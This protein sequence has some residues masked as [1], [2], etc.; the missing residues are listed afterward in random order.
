MH[1]PGGSAG[2]WT[3]HK[4][5]WPV[6]LPPEPLP[7]SGRQVAEACGGGGPG[8]GAHAAS[9]GGWQPKPPRRP[10]VTQLPVCSRG[11]T[12]TQVPRRSIHSGPGHQGTAVRAARKAPGARALPASS[13]G[14][15]WEAHGAGGGLTD[16]F[17]FAPF[18]TPEDDG[19]PGRRRRTQGLHL[20]HD[21]DGL[22]RLERPVL[23]PARHEGTVHRA[24][25]LKG[26]LPTAARAAGVPEPRSPE[27]PAC[28][29]SSA[30]ADRPK[31]PGFVHW[32][33]QP[34]THCGPSDL[35]G[36]AQAMSL[37]RDP[38]QVARAAQGPAVPAT[39]TTLLGLLSH[40][41]CRC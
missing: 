22:L 3:T 29:G 18:Q 25:G 17:L 7:S 16:S 8:P 23:C 33:P 15:V 37:S 34:A 5:W 11:Q 1:C 31:F 13:A 9:S 14:R 36:A 12:P 26:V 24:L 6:L 10:R 41:I 27:S 28:L 30:Q 2:C 38:R 4:S 21:A 40:C 19:R 39:C 20:G 35:G 32:H